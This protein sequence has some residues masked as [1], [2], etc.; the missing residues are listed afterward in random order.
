MVDWVLLPL[1]LLESNKQIH[2][3]STSVKSV[4]LLDNVPTVVVYKD[5]LMET[6]LLD[7]TASQ[8]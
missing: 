8:K 2:K 4:T 1:T 5:I 7:E 6:Y 3:K